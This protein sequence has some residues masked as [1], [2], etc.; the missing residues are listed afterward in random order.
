MPFGAAAD[1][2]TDDTAVIQTAIDALASGGIINGEGLTYAVGNL[3]LKSN[4]TMLNFDL[5]E[6]DGSATDFSPVNIGNDLTTVNGSHNSTAGAAARTASIASPGIQNVIIDNVHIDGNRAGQTNVDYNT[7]GVENAQRDGGRHGF[8]LKG[9]TTN[10]TI[11]NSSANYCATD[12]ILIYRGLHTWQTISETNPTHVNLTVRN[13]DFGWNRRH[14][15]AGDS[16]A[17]AVFKDCTF[18]DNGQTINGGATIGE[19][20]ARVGVNHYGNGF[21]M[22]GYGLSSRVSD[23]RFDRCELLRNIRDGLLMYDIVDHDLA[24]FL[25]RTAVFVHRCTLDHGTDNVNG[26]QAMTFTST[27]GNRAKARLY[28]DVIVH[29]CDID[30]IYLFRS[31]EAIVSRSRQTVPVGNANRVTLDNADA[32]FVGN[33]ATSTTTAS[34]FQSTY[35]DAD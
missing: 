5:V 19:V 18:N 27:I 9:F 16:I 17:G 11:R 35:L 12:G 23:I 22:E 1:G 26:D 32:V 21:D 34:S 24:S 3:W 13:C 2:V 28:T 7:E 30:G 25:P 14:G 6:L 33:A 4:M 29:D 20:G 10:V 8:C 15:G 31:A